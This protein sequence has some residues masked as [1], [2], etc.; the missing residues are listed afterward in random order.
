MPKDLVFTRH[1]GVFF[2]LKS[3]K[4]KYRDEKNDKNNS[5]LLDI[6]D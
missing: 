2:I 1:L 5:I 6:K 4:N 3:K